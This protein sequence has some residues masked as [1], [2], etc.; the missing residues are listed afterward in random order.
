MLSSKGGVY[1]VREKLAQ[2]RARKYW[3][4]EDAASKIGVSAVTLHKWE[5]GKSTPHPR[6]IQR[7]CDLYGVSAYELD[8][9]ECA[10]PRLA[11][12]PSDEQQ[13]HHSSDSKP[14]PLF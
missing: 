2:A 9:E 5:H 1:M 6:N 14:T 3:T 12:L 7:L 11:P 10:D 8:L 13:D 4:L